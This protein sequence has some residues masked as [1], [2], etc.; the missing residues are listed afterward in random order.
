MGSTLGLI[1]CNKILNKSMISVRVKS[2]FEY[3]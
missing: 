3:F 2:S 1:P